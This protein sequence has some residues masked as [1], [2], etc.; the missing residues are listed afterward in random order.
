MV[1]EVVDFQV[2]IGTEHDQDDFSMRYDMTALPVLDGDII[3]CA[4]FATVS[5]GGSQWF[6]D[7]GAGN[8]RK[9]SGPWS[10][11]VTLGTAWDHGL[12]NSGGGFDV[13]GLLLQTL[14]T[15]IAD[16][17]V[18]F[19]WAGG[20]FTNNLPLGMAV[21]VVRGNTYSTLAD[22]DVQSQGNMASSVARTWS[23][24]LSLTGPLADNQ[25]FFG[26]GGAFNNT[27]THQAAVVSDDFTPAAE[28]DIAE[29]WTA[30]Q[31]Y[32]NT[33]F[34][35]Y[36]LPGGDDPSS[37][38]TTWVLG[39]GTGS[40]IWVA[41]IFGAIVEFDE[42][43]VPPRPQA[44]IELPSTQLNLKVFPNRLTDATLEGFE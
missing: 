37:I 14:T 31:P 22:S 28:D 17:M 38:A 1:A 4:L 40:A 10:D 7:Y 35:Q 44:T 25:L 33:M 43:F 36:A 34:A 20:T 16:G 15:Q 19:G 39:A 3:V 2:F 30:F 26:W 6:N 11:I 32:D 29:A 23:P 42:S 9:T 41:D 18:A 27:G 21:W 24:S 12:V 5:G 13:G 8:T